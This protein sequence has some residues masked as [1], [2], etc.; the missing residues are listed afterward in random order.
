MSW[1]ISAAATESMI[2]NQGPKPRARRASW[3]GR[4]SPPL[5]RRQK[6]PS[7]PTPP[8]L[9]VH[10]GWPGRLRIGVSARGKREVRHD[11]VRCRESAD[12]DNVHPQIV[13]AVP[14]VGVHDVELTVGG[15]SQPEILTITAPPIIRA[16]PPSRHAHFRAESGTAVG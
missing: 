5:R 12:C 13:S 2:P 3:D 16:C 14:I 11:I 8:A 1:T 15:G 10:C 4:Q 7:A 9:S 6:R